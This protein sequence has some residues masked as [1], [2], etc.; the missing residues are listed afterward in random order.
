M[1]KVQTTNTITENQNKNQWSK[2]KKQAI[3]FKID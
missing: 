3:R 1:K 2:L